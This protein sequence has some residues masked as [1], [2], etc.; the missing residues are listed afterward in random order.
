M[1]SEPDVYSIEDLSRD[2]TTFWN[3]VRNYA[4]RGHLRAMQKGDLAFFYHSNAEPSAIVG[5][6]RVAKEAR[7]DPTQFDEKAGE[8]MG[9]DPKS[10]KD[11][12]RWFG[13]DVAFVEKLA[14][15]VTL[16]DVKAE[17]AL[18]NMKL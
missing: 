5:V 1:K 7:S 2:K 14:R 15:P 9:Y 13:V 12:P 18:K 17:S 10:R 8:D 3:G 11:D 16:A 4:A 6:V